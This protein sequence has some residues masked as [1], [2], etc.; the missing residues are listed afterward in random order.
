M[1][2]ACRP[3]CCTAL[4]CL[5]WGTLLSAARSWPANCLPPVASCQVADEAAASAYS[6]AALHPDGLIL[7]T[8]TEDAAVRIWETRTSKNVAKFDG[9]EGRINRIS[10]SENG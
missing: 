5:A 10:F 8:G 4:P 1:L 2:R 3:D 9:H 7:C 6:C